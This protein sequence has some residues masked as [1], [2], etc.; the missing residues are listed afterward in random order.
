MRLTVDASTVY[1]N[2]SEEKVTLKRKFKVTIFSKGT[3]ICQRVFEFFKFVICMSF[4][5]LYDTEEK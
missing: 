3:F 2:I 1:W 5:Y 4:Y